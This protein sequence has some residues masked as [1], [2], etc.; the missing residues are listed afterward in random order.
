MTSWMLV[1]NACEFGSSR[2]A[3]VHVHAGSVRI[4]LSEALGQQHMRVVQGADAHDELDAG[5][6]R[7]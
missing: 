1:R 2:A 6:Q 4:V 3:V 7:V 5:A